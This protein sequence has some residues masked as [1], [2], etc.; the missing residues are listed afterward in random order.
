MLY[1]P[2]CGE[3]RA[4][5]TLAGV[6]DAGGSKVTTSTSYKMTGVLDG[7]EYVTILE[8][9]FTAASVPFE[10][11]IPADLN[12]GT[13]VGKL[14]VSALF[15]TIAPGVGRSIEVTGGE[16]WGPL[17]GATLAAYQ[18]VV[19]AGYDDLVPGDTACRQEP[20]IGVS[21]INVPVP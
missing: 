10:V 1:V 4:R 14:S 15:S 17:G 3:G 13:G 5:A 7:T 20:M 19:N 8:G 6:T 9:T 21:G 12:S 16:V 11:A 18:A 2:I